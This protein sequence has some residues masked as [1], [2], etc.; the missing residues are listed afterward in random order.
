MSC[1]SSSP[2]IDLGSGKLARPNYLPAS[3][4]SHTSCS[5][6]LG[7]FTVKL[8]RRLS[9]KANAAKHRNSG[10]TLTPQGLVHLHATNDSPRAGGRKDFRAHLSPLRCLSVG[11]SPSGLKQGKGSL[12]SSM[13]DVENECEEGL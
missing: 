3:P 6:A 1:L 13:G 4:E 7:K 9:Y 5:P 11:V 8:G 12:G 10:D 2:P